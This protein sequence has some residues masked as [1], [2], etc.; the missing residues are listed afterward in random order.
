M[1]LDPR[2]T[3]ERKIANIAIASSNRSFI[4]SPGYAQCRAS[5]DVPVDA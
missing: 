1:S 2:N 5:G 4:A 3:A